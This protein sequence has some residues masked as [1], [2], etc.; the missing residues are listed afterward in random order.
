MIPSGHPENFVTSF[1]VEGTPQ[2]GGSKRAFVIKGTN[3][4]VI[5][6]ANSK[7]S[8]WKSDVKVYA[9]LAYRGAVLEGPLRVQAQFA[10][11]RPKHHYGT[12]KNSNT[13]K[14]SAPHYPTSKPDATKLWRPT[15]DALTGIIWKDDAQIVSQCIEKVYADRPGV[16]ICVERM[17]K[18]GTNIYRV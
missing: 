15:E 16:F 5:T 2:P 4:A 11:V 12:G 9:R 13:L 7:A 8:A 1:S 18:N 10:Q 14:P 3:R 6:D 17:G